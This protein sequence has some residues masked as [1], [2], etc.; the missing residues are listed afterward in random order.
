MAT[1]Q[2][3]EIEEA[4]GHK[5]R[6]LELV[7]EA[8]THGS[9]VQAT[10]PSCERLAVLG[11]AA[12][13][14]YIGAQLVRK[15]QFPTAA[16][17]TKDPACQQ[18]MAFAMPRELQIECVQEPRQP[19]AVCMDIESLR[20]RLLACCNHVSYAYTC[21]KLNLHK[22]LHHNAEGLKPAVKRFA[23]AV[24]RGAKWEEL[25]ARG[26]PKTLGDVFLAC[27]GAVVLDG[28]G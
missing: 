1:Q 11:E 20:Q 10:T 22:A 18:A 13:Q 4:L 26:A 3:P 24:G 17:A 6:N 27:V 2:L 5:F 21:V 25:I 28:G 19:A 8:L 23:K 7:A 9:V 12:T 15:A 14:S 16:T